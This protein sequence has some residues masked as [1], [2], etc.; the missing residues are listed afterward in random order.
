MNALLWY[1][2]LI[3]QQHFRRASLPASVPGGRDQVSAGW[4]H[5][6]IR[7]NAGPMSRNDE[8]R[9]GSMLKNLLLL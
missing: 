6:K 2:D 9:H 3:P 7:Y 1:T 5:V 8:K 4:I